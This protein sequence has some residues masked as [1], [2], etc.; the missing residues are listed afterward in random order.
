MSIIFARKFSLTILLNLS[1]ISYVHA[2]LSSSGPLNGNVKDYLAAYYALLDNVYM[3]DETHRVKVGDSSLTTGNPAITH[4]MEVIVMINAG[5]LDECCW[6]GEQTTYA[7]YYVAATTN[8]VLN[9]T[10]VPNPGYPVW[11]TWR[12]TFTAPDVYADVMASYLAELVTVSGVSLQSLPEG[13]DAVDYVSLD[14]MHKLAADMSTNNGLMDNIYWHFSYTGSAFRYFSGGFKNHYAWACIVCEGAGYYDTS[15]LHQT[16]PGTSSTYYD[17][18][19]TSE[20]LPNSYDWLQARPGDKPD[21]QVSIGL[22]LQVSADQSLTVGDDLHGPST[23]PVHNHGSEELYFFLNPYTWSQTRTDNTNSY[24][25]GAI[26]TDNLVPVFGEDMASQVVSV[27]NRTFQEVGNAD[28]AYNGTWVYHAMHPGKYAQISAWSRLTHPE[29]GTFFPFNDMPGITIGMLD[30]NPDSAVILQ[31]HFGDIATRR[32]CL[33]NDSTCRLL[34]AGQSVDT[35]AGNTAYAMEEFI[36]L[37]VAANSIWAAND[38][39][40]CSEQGTV[41]NPD[42]EFDITYMFHALAGRVTGGVD[43][44]TEVIRDSCSGVY[45]T[46]CA[47]QLLT[48]LCFVGAS[49]D[50]GINDVGGGI[51][52]TG[53]IKDIIDGAGG[54][55]GGINDIIR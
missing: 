32:S 3:G 18:L 53:G 4:M 20:Y 38:P 31:Q 42:E 15:L 35:A 26:N 22:T 9:Q 1:L 7:D 43:K 8:E 44:V 39:L 48:N 27:N 40:G 17:L 49:T 2:D 13:L 46:D 21:L 30:R 37:M 34:Y 33:V 16:K 10:T 11:D 29:E 6:R 51:G 47:D 19:V 45:T 41:N 23:Y 36:E 55:G 52:G 12:N 50:D 28:I 25:A 14:I 54:I 24:V 5:L